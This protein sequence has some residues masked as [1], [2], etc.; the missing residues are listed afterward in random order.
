MLSELSQAGL[1]L[2]PGAWS[3]E[4]DAPLR[5][6]VETASRSPGLA[7]AAPPPARLWIISRPAAALL[8]TYPSIYDQVQE[9]GSPW[10]VK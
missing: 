6:P 8:S 9:S 3:L 7:P 5:V 4:A 10:S 2:E 1:S